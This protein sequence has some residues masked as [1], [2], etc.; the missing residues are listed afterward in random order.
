[1]DDKMLIPF[2]SLVNYNYHHDKSFE[3]CFLHISLN[4]E[5]CQKED[6]PVGNKTI[7]QIV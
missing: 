5:K 1:M 2:M 6:L 7:L 3:Q 4:T